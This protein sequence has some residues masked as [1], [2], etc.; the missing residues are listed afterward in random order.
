[1]VKLNNFQFDDV[2]SIDVAGNCRVWLNIVAGILAGILVG[3]IVVIG[4]AIIGT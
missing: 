1:M 3:T 4:G 2:E